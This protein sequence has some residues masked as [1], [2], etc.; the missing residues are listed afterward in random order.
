M[1]LK[2]IRRDLVSNRMIYAL[3][4]PVIAYYLVFHYVPMYGASIAFKNF[5]PTKGILG[6]EWVGFEHF[7]SFF[8]SHYFWRVLRNT[9]AI[10]G[11]QLLFGFPAPIL[12][13][14]MLN[15]LRSEAFKRTVQTISY[16]PHFIS[17]MVISGL[18]L[19]FGSRTG[20][21]NDLIVMFGGERSN[22]LMR[23][24]LFR[25]IYV[26]TGIWQGVGWNSIIYLAALTAIDPELYQAARIDGA[27]RWKQTFHVTLPGILPT[28]SILLILQ[29]GQMM[30]VGFEKII[31]LYN[32]ATYETA[33][34]ISSFVYRKGLMEFN[35]S[36]SAAVGLFN[37]V[38]NFAL[39]IGANTVSKRVN[40]TS[41]W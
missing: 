36:Y 22:L 20:V 13:A 8:S 27:G 19:N 21:A 35:Y 33:D 25:L 29:I 3:A 1:Q 10:N 23:P 5:V 6:S 30:N 34:V 17:I 39:L 15:E 16:M 9:V 2:K 7:A 18:I 26:S 40:E 28:I 38:I 32:G 11:Y 31:L 4:I 14:L 24:E 37:S 41:L 12:L